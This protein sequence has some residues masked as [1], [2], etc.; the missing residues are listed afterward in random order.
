[1][2]RRYKRDTTHWLLL[3]RKTKKLDFFLLVYIY[4]YIYTNFGAINDNDNLLK[5]VY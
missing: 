4:K 5:N 2:L 1:M 3:R